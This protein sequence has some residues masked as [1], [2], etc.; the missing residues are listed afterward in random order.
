VAAAVVFEERVVI[1]LGLR[2]LADA[3]RE[4]FLFRIHQRG[5]S[6]FEA[7]APDA[8]RF[9]PSAL[10]HRRFRLEWHRDRSGYWAFDLQHREDP[11]EG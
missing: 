7:V 11:R 9:Q 6:G 10:F 5:P 3:R 8:D 4:P 1:P 2:S